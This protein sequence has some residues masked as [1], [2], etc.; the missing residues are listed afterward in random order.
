MSERLETVSTPDE[1][2]LCERIMDTS[3]WS[4]LELQLLAPRRAAIPPTF[5]HRPYTRA[6]RQA[7][8][9]V[10]RDRRHAKGRNLVVRGYLRVRLQAGRK[11]FG[12]S[13]AEMR[14]KVSSRGVKLSLFRPSEMRA[15]LPCF[16][17]CGELVTAPAPAHSRIALDDKYDL[18]RIL[19]CA[20]GWQGCNAC[21]VQYDWG[22][23]WGSG[24]SR[25]WS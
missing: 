19:N 22:W 13:R 15:C 1:R 14:Q 17:P 8:Q 21:T 16:R 4:L 3:L 20:M 24:G 7:S 12:R 5:A 10:G 23:G 9:R 2:A 25:E 6:S 11:P 18:E